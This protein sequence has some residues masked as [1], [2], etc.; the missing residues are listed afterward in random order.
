MNS[1]YKSNIHEIT[2]N[3]LTTVTT[4]ELSPEGPG[5]FWGSWDGGALVKLSPAAS[6]SGTKS[7][8][9]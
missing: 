8:S 3:I 5:I 9:L 1:T 2:K 4:L 7:G 6:P